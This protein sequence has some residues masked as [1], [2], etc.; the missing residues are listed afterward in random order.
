M[1]GEELRFSDGPRSIQ[2][3]IRPQYYHLLRRLHLFLHEWG[4]SLAGM[5]VAL[6]DQRPAGKGDTNTL[7]WSVR[8]DGH[9]GFVFINNYERLANLPAKTNVQF[10]VQLPGGPMTF[11][12]QPVTVPADCCSFWPFNF[13]LGHGINLIS[14][15]AQPLCAMDDGGIRTVFFAETKGVPAEF[16]FDK[17][18]SLKSP[19]GKISAQGGQGRSRASWKRAGAPHCKFP[20]PLAS[21]RSSC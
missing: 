17:T 9:S 5:G 10:T 8:S 19:S 15:T 12:E 7:R 1:H 20:H 2:I 13:D 3:Q 4:S 16:I 21:C 6:P 14:A 11:P 18:V